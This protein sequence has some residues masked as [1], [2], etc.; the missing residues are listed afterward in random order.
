M[1]RVRMTD[2]SDSDYAVLPYLSM[3]EHSVPGATGVFRSRHGIVDV[4]TCPP[5]RTSQG[6][7]HLS[8]ILA[9]RCYHRT[10]HTRWP[11]RT[12]ARLAREFADDAID[13]SDGLLG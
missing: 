5:S 1:N 13:Q 7:T 3:R 10:W 11:N 8:F 9:G 12:I 2:H 6:Y 4:Y